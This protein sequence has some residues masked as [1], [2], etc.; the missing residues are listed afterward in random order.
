M[1]TLFHAP[2]ARALAAHRLLQCA[3]AVKGPAPAGGQ[4]ALAAA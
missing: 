4:P 3:I 1:P 2:G